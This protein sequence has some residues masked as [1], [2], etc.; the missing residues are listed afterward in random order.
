MSEYDHE[1]QAEVIAA[2]TKRATKPEI[3]SVSDPRGGVALLLMSTAAD[4]RQGAVSAKGLLD[5]WR[6]TP[7]RRKG[8]A[9]ALTLQ[10]FIGLVNRHGDPDSAV[11]VEL[12][13]PRFTAVIDYN[14]DVKR[15]E[16]DVARY[17][18]HRIVYEFPL[19]EQA[20]T[21]MGQD[22]KEMAQAAFAEFISD[23][24]A[25]LTSRES[26]DRELSAMFHTTIAEPTE[27]MQLSRGLA[28]RVETTVVNSKI[29]ESG[30]TEFV[31]QEVHLDGKP[32]EKSKLVVPG[33]FLLAIPLFEADDAVRIA[34]RLRYR[35][36]G[37][38]ISWTYRL[39]RLNEVLGDRV[40][41]C[42]GEVETATV[43]PAYFGTP[44]A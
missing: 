32:G 42:A 35:V 5:E 24:I 43:L 29:V 30:E 2:L 1:G 7:D 11:F 38:K 21:W 12:K 20:K 14:R 22:G 4:G 37:G 25:D 19:T 26:G 39:Y 40:E 10:S 34:A 44:E 41:H 9:K 28:V 15:T 8:I 33:L 16:G 3:V 13:P 27:M 6:T 36:S 23:N 17:G 18:Q 31:V